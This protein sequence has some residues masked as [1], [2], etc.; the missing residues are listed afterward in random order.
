MSVYVEKDGYYTS[1]EKNRISF[2]YAEK[3]DES[4][5]KPDPSTPVIFHLRKKQTAD[6]MIRLM[7]P[8]AGVIF[9]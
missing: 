7:F 3:T 6:A 2:E 5:Y 9:W 1:R 8:R 4:F